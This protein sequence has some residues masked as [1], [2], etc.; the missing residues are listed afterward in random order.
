[1]FSPLRCLEQRQP[2]AAPRRR[3]RSELSAVPSR[4][5]AERLL[6]RNGGEWRWWRP[7]ASRTSSLPG[8]DRPGKASNTSTR[9]RQ[10]YLTVRAHDSIA[11]E[12]VVATAGR[13][14]R[15]S[16]RLPSVFHRG[17]LRACTRPVASRRSG[18]QARAAV[19]RGVRALQS[20][21]LK[22]KVTRQCAWGRTKIMHIQGQH[23]EGTAALACRTAASSAAV[24][25]AAA[26]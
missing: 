20:R 24:R 23:Y 22:A 5:G 7:C 11:E 18:T 26:R 9:G 3:R 6:S 13:T 19:L 21:R 10:A 15:A 25:G 2:Q 17:A 4:W 8:D 14:T 16:R 12:H 1:L